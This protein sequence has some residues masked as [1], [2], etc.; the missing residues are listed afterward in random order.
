MADKIRFHFHNG[1][2]DF[3]VGDNEFGIIDYSGIEAAEYDI[4][5]KENISG[6][7]SRLTKRKISGRDISLTAEYK[8]RDGNTSRVREFLLAF[9][10]PLSSGVLTVENAGKRCVTAYEVEKFEYKYTNIHERVRF[11]LELTCLDPAMLAEYSESDQMS[12]WIGGWKLKFTLP[13]CLRHRGPK[14]KT[15]INGGHLDTPIQVIFQGPAEN[16]RI[17]NHTTGERMIVNRTLTEG[18]FLH[19]NTDPGNISVQIERNGSLEDA[20][21]YIDLDTDFF[22]LR[23]GENRIEY[24]TDNELDPQ[25]VVIIHRER[26]LGI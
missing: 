12:T 20:Y 18:D 6:Y 5:K 4:Q 10:S 25:Q 16:P 1:K 8:F 24:G 7:G 13:F 17:I 15:I 19:I 26:Y 11:H 14:Q 22:Q 2:T 23:P 9:F 3:S 21:G